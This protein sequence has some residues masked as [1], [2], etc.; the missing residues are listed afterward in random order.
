MQHQHGPNCRHG[1]S[2]AGH[3]PSGGHQMPHGLGFPNQQQ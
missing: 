1:H 2:S 3:G